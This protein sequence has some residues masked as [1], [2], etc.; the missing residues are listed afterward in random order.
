MRFFKIIASD[1]VAGDGI[2][3]SYLSAFIC[4]YKT[5]RKLPA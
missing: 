5:A 1:V 4:G 2:K 3:Y